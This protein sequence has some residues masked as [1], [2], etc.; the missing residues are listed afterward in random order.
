MGLGEPDHGQSQTGR[1]LLVHL[2]G[3][4]SK[5]RFV[6]NHLLFSIDNPSLM[7]LS[8]FVR[9]S[10][11]T[12]DNQRIMNGYSEI[13]DNHV[14]IFLEEIFPLRGSILQVGTCRILSLAENPR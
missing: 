11:N 14:S 8:L 4:E 5:I 2:R 7:I 6:A 13:T 10:A 9:L 1:Q 3:P 12:P